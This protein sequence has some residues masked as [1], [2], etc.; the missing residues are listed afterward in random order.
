MIVRCCLLLYAYF[1]FSEEISLIKKQAAI[2]GNASMSALGLQ[3]LHKV[4]WT[5]RAAF[6]LSLV[7]GGLS[8]FYACL[9]QQKLRSLFTT[10]DVKNF[11]SRPSTSLAMFKFEK[12][13]DKILAGLRAHNADG[14]ANVECL[15]RIQEL[16]ATVKDFKTKNRWKSASFHSIL[17]VKTP[18][19]LLK[20][21]VGFF[22]V[23]LG[24]YFGGLATRD[25]DAQIPR[26]RY[27]LVFAAYFVGTLLALFIYYLPATLKD[28]ELA[29]SR[30]YVWLVMHALWKD[31]S[32]PPPKEIL[33]QLN[34]IFNSSCFN[35]QESCSIRARDD[36]L[37]WKERLE[38]IKRPQNC[39]L[40]DTTADRRVDSRDNSCSASVNHQNS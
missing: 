14:E 34:K 7:T 17:M 40:S 13:L 39:A 4:N 32:E 37:S 15:N 38:H 21:S 19:L 18:T 33:E 12:S 11:F 10:E 35:E 31:T 36:A 22:I 20:Y 26:G 28:L 29:P 6:V 23:G 30:R 25:G 5:A 8:V 3:H 9:I 24:I 27:K 2:I 16:E 1:T